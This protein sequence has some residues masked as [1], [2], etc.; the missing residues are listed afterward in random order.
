MSLQEEL[1]ARSEGR[2]ELCTGTEALAP[3][4]VAPKSTDTA[5][6]AVMLCGKCRG[7]LQNTAS[8]EE[9]HWQALSQTMW[10]EHAPV[11]VM[12]WRVLQA[13]KGQGWAQDLLD[14]LYL[15]DTVRD[16][17][18][19]AAINRETQDDGPATRDS[20][21]TVLQ[22]GDAVTLIKDLDVKGAN[23]TAKRGTMVKGITLTGDPGLIEGR[24]NGI[25]IVLKTE[26][27]KKA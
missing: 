11:Q 2:C 5:D 26:F 8:M 21:G 1:M 12:V 4:G 24:V 3:Y 27:L 18:Q 14:Q 6:H 23:F 9:G 17:A 16:W 7:Q 19:S 15:D 25:K 10:S 22:E 20:N 13:F